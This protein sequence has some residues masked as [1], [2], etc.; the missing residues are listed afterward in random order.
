M[1]KQARELVI[2]GFQ[3][4]GANGR[5]VLTYTIEDHHQQNK[6]RINNMMTYTWENLKVFKMVK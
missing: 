4:E 5:Q 2:Q 6:L 1:T 3:L